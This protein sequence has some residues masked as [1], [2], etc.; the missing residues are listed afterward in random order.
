MIKHLSGLLI[1]LLLIPGIRAQKSLDLTLEYP[2]GSGNFRNY[3][4]YEPQGFDA[5]DENILMVGFHPFNPGTWDGKTW[6]DTLKSYIELIDALLICPDGGG[7]GRIDDADDYAFI[8]A[9][10]DTIQTIYTIDQE[11][12]YGI[13]FSIG[14]K[15]VYEYSFKNPD[16][17][18]GMIPIGAAIDGVDF[19]D[20]ISNSKCYPYYQVHGQKDNPA[21]RYFP[22][23]ADLEF[24]GALVTGILMADVGH[25][26]NFPNRNTVLKNAFT[27]IDTSECDFSGLINLEEK[28]ELNIYPNFIFAGEEINIEIESNVF[29][30][31]VYSLGSQSL[32]MGPTKRLNEQA[33]QSRPQIIKLQTTDWPSGLVI[34]HVNYENGKNKTGIVEVRR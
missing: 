29:D 11:R 25:T 21:V 17:L 10:I 31:K 20:V 2:A 33:T 27:F 30:I 26:I 6:R 3:S 9:L 1:A 32:G 23:K 12:I 34:V 14:G 5:N 16:K 19:S 15:A 4:L 13:G 8:T 18:K 28:E 24:N 22:I 7:N